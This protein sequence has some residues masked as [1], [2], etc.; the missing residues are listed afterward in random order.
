M[1]ALLVHTLEPFTRYA[2]PTQLAIEPALGARALRGR[3]LVELGAQEFPHF[4]PE[5]LGRRRQLAELE[6]KRG[7]QSY[8]SRWRSS[9]KRPWASRGCTQAMSLSAR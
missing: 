7:H 4:R 1:W 5:R 8:A 2:P 9:T 6:V 3:V